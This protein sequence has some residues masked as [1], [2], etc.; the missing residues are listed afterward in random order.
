[1]AVAGAAKRALQSL[2]G[3]SF[4][5]PSPFTWSGA[6]QLGSKPYGTLAAA[7]PAEKQQAESAGLNSRILTEPLKHPDFFHV[8]ELFS[9]KDLF[10]AK[11]HLGHKRGCRHSLMEP[12]I[13]GCRLEQDI[14]DLDQS[15]EHLQ[16]ALNVAA[17]IAYRK[18]IILFVGRN[19]QFVHLLERTAKDCGEYAHTRYWRGGL[20]TNSHVQYSP[21]VRLPDL[22]IFL[23]TLNNVFEQHV[24]V[25]DATKMNI[26]TVG[27]VDT[28]C[29]PSLI[30]YPVPGN[31][32]SPSAVEMYCRLFKMTINR[33]KEKRKQMEILY[34]LKSQTTS[35]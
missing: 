10:D 15:R 19:R 1:M 21:G 32:D 4:H 22:I 2:S 3:S 9:L 27:V 33:A 11:V 28:N 7:A 6:L 29:N 24:A 18:G 31:D 17:H 35:N 20:L 13:F 25:R 23:S 5:G 8:K 16:L 12:Y 30:T 26:P 34:G 14:I